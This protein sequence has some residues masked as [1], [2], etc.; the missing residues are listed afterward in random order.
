MRRCGVR[1]QSLTSS[2]FPF[3][4]SNDNWLSHRLDLT[5]ASVAYLLEPQWNPMMEE[6]ALC[7]IHR[8][9]QRK[10]VKTIRYRIRGSFEEVRFL[11]QLLIFNCRT[12]VLTLSQKVVATQELKKEI[13]AEAFSTET[14]RNPLDNSK[15][16]QVSSQP[17]P[18]SETT[19]AKNS[20]TCGNNW[21][22]S[23][24]ESLTRIGLKSKSTCIH[25]FMKNKQ[26]PQIFYDIALIDCRIRQ[27]NTWVNKF[28]AAGGMI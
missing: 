23:R 1:C 26:Q 24:A 25:S 6:Q 16:L 4:S 27:N 8:L 5:A 11:V 3:K 13:A 22:K 18:S 12:K 9:G 17:L 21:D 7:R 10:E 2:S 28:L 20:S 14:R 19:L 15:R